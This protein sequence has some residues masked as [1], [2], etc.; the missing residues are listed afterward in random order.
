VSAR[1]FGRYEVRN[2]LYFVRK[3]CLSISRC[4]LG[5]TIRLAMSIG[6]GLASLN[7]GLLLRA[8]GNIEELMRQ[9]VT[10]LTTT[11]LMPKR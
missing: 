7:A 10:P 4:Y 3:H 11:P 2:R 8:L 1:A 6:S 9:S 5:L